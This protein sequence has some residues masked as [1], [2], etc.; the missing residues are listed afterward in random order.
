MH[1]S[2]NYL[3]LDPD[4]YQ[5]DIPDKCDAPQLALWNHSLATSLGITQTPENDEAQL[6][7]WFSGHQIIPGSQ[8]IALAYAGH[9]YGQLV[10]QLGDGRAHLLGEIAS[11]N[12][13][14]IELQLKGSGATPF[15]RGGDGK[16]GLGPAIRE[17]IMSE[18]MH[19]L[20]VPS[21]RSLSV[22][23]TGQTV[24]R[25]SP[26]AGAVVCRASSSHIRIGTFQYF[27]IRNK[28]SVL[29]QLIDLSIQR[30]FPEL[31]HLKGP[32]KVIAFLDS[33]MKNTAELMYHWMRVGFI[34]GVMNTDNAAINAHTIDFGPCAMLGKYTPKAVY[35]S[36]DRRGRYAFGNQSN[37]SQWNLARLAECLLPLID[38]DTNK[39]VAI[40]TAM[41]DE[42]PSMFQK[43]YSRMMA[44]KIGFEQACEPS[45]ELIA[46]LLSLM[47]QHE[48]DY[49]NTFN[50]LRQSISNV[51]VS[52]AIKK[53]NYQVLEQW[54]N[55]WQTL[56]LK[57]SSKQQAMDVMAKTNPLVIPRNYLV[58]N[59]IAEA[60]EKGDLTATYSLLDALKKPYDIL[61]RD[62]CFFANYHEYDQTYKTYCGT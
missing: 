56:L 19:D 25:Q 16:C 41:I 27:A 13:D 11:S 42:Y 45:N 28:L 1:L 10:P 38:T 30:N 60:N 22:V 34:H 32:E 31:L 49:T 15:S 33:V 36:I 58:E 9:Q 46:S 59:A 43:T 2:N 47:E 14:T 50:V 35:S 52:A 6:A 39:A 8:P 61:N 44:N 54:L 26:Q 23:T 20:G 57:K 51:V 21:M 5:S 24:Y 40:A 29:E 48:L 7:N 3:T 37:I 4:L 12:N 62:A 17:Y 55:E 53:E 18:A